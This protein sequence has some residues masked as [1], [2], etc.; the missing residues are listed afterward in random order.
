MM[1]V[2]LLHIQELRGHG[3]QRIGRQLVVAVHVRQQV[4]DNSAINVRFDVLAL[5]VG[6]ALESSLPHNSLQSLHPAEVGKPLQY[7]ILLF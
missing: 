1:N 2:L 4:K 5:S 6:A 3:I 7:G